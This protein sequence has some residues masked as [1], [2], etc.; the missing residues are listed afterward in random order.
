MKMGG[1]SKATVSFPV[2]KTVNCLVSEVTPAEI[3]T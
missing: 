2:I 1:V 3:W